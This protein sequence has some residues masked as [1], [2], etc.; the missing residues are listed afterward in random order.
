MRGTH[1]HLILPLFTS[2]LSSIEL[3]FL[4]IYKSSHIPVY[5]SIVINPNLK[6]YLWWSSPK[7]MLHISKCHSS[8]LYP[9]LELLPFCFISLTFINYFYFE[10]I[11]MT[12]CKMASDSSWWGH[13]GRA[14]VSNHQPRYDL[15]AYSMVY[16]GAD[17]RKHQS[18][19]SMAFVLGIHRGPV[20]SPHKWPVT[21]KMFPFDDVIMEIS[22][23]DIRIETWIN[24]YIH[25]KRYDM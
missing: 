6:M 8:E 20:N 25:L 21:W 3:F 12:K 17:Q 11:P 16:P 2:I 18:S 23:I 22:W 24:N 15:I 1:Y 7:D 10:C 13:N 4:I 5:I 19:A 14:S 9:Q